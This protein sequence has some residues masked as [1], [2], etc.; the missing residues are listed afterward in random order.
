M[1][2][3]L[4]AIFAVF[5]FAISAITFASSAAE[6]TSYEIV[7]EKDSE[8][9]ATV[10]RVAPSTDERHLSSAAEATEINDSVVLENYQSIAIVWSSAPYEVGWTS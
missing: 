5:T 9:V 8:M 2:K 1:R 3:T 4:F 6:E 7:Q 10:S